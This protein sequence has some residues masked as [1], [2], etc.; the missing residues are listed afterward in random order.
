VREDWGLRRRWRLYVGCLTALVAVLGAL[1][2]VV[3]GHAPREVLVVEEPTAT[4]TATPSPGETP[5]PTATT[6]PTEE[7]TASGAPTPDPGGPAT[8]NP[9]PE[10]PRL[11]LD[12]DHLLSDGYLST[13]FGS[14]RAP[15]VGTGDGGA[16]AA[17]TLLVSGAAPTTRIA[18]ARMWSWPGEV[19]VGETFA[20]TQ[21]PDDASE[22]LRLCRSP[23]LAWGRSG[24]P[25]ELDLGDESFL[26]RADGALADEAMAG[27]RVGRE[28]VF[29]VWRQ[30]GG[31]LSTEA[32]ARAAADALSKAR[33]EQLRG[34]VAADHRATPSTL[35]GFPGYDDLRPLMH[36]DGSTWDY[37]S[38]W[39][40]HDDA[41]SFRCNE[42]EDSWLRPGGPM[43]T[44]YFLG[45]VLNAMDATHVGLTLAEESDEATAVARFDACRTASHGKP[46]A[47][48]GDEAFEAE[49]MMTLDG[50]EYTVFVRVGSRYVVLAA[51]N[52]QHWV[53][54]ARAAVASLTAAGRL[55]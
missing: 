40:D 23:D 46:V 51:Y 30:T 5:E 7:P 14:G 6:G 22:A 38:W 32:L 39:A 50:N 27:I 15:F 52:E 42:S 37:L 1:L 53:E 34:P 35:T 31:L 36:P 44:R 49:P 19:V 55:G 17:C 11:Q 21:S 2:V 16:A 48:L 12:A 3:H 18:V 43:V 13:A 54:M 26:W 9:S 4:P 24:R 8:P 20:R 47:G 33:E 10:V 25:L 45:G 41:W 28:L 29:L